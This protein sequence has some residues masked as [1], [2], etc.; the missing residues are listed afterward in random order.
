MGLAILEHL[1][2]A[3]Q[4]EFFLKPRNMFPNHVKHFMDLIK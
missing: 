3:K 1:Q 2:M 4:L